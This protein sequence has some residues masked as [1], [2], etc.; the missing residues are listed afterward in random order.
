MSSEF[1]VF[2]VWGFMV[3]W[4]RLE[5]GGLNDKIHNGGIICCYADV[6]H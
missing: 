2:Y 4:V 1:N 5:G 3:G 6:T